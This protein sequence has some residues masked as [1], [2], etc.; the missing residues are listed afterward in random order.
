MADYRKTKLGLL[1]HGERFVYIFDFGDD[2]THVCAVAEERIDL[3]ETLG[4]LLTGRFHTGG[5]EISPISTQGAGT[6][7]TASPR[8]PRIR[9]GPIQ[10]SSNTGG[11]DVHPCFGHGAAALDACCCGRRGR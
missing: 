1:K 10:S 2:R 6:E 4:I 9:A 7:T 3:V 11:G 5:G 8:R